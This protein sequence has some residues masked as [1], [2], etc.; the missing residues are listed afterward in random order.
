MEETK[1]C[2]YCGEE[3][4]AQAIKCKHC[5]EFLKTP[6]GKPSGCVVCGVCIVGIILL[7]GIIGAFLPDSYDADTTNDI[8]QNSSNSYHSEPDGVFGS[9]SGFGDWA[10]MNANYGGQMNNCLENG[11]GMSLTEQLQSIYDNP[12]P[13][14]YLLPYRIRQEN[15]RLSFIVKEPMW[16]ESVNFPRMCKAT[17]EFTEINPNT[18]LSLRNNFEYT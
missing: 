17:V 18:N 4:K 12:N 6:A 11:V 7:L 2:P 8:V 10:V 5:G 13:K 1:K 14:R 15:K 16:A 9:Y 3:I